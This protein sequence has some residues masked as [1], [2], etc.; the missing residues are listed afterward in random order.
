MSNTP[1]FHDRTVPAPP[2][3]FGYKTAWFAISSEDMN[4]VA[5]ALELQNPQAA[6]W[7]YGVWHAVESDDYAIFVTPPV[8]GWI[9]A[10]GV[11]ILYEA[12][13]HATERMIELSQQFGEAQF[14]ASMRVSD[15]YVWA[16]AVQGKLIRL[17]C[18]GD[19]ERREVGEQTSAEKALG[20]SFFNAASPEASK[21]GY[22]ERK[23]LVSPD[24]EH[25]LAIASQWSVNPIKLDQ[26]GVAPILG[27]LGEA[28]TSYPPRPQPIRRKTLAT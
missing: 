28:S 16:R 24:E 18:E 22:W 3:P 12:D 15:A 8:D 25:V 9:L 13:D 19:G 17:F 5:S 6:N 1:A 20:V 11:P 14:F 10:V 21:P 23:D 7:E 26:R 2:V 27:L 4:A